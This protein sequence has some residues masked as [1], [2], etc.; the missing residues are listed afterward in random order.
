MNPPTPSRRQFLQTSLATAATF[1]TLSGRR[2]FAAEAGSKPGFVREDARDLPLINDANV[3]VCGAGPAGVTAAISAARAGAKVRLFEAHGSLGGVW[4]SSLLG[5]LLDFDKPGFNVELVRRLRE[6]DAINGSGMNGLSYQPEEMKLLLEELCVESGVKVQLHTRVAAAY[7]EGRSLSTIVTESKS[8][9][10]AWKAP[11]FID[12]TGD[13]DLGAQAGCEFEIGREKACPC[14]PMT[15]Y[16][17]LVVKDVAQIADCMHGTGDGGRHVGPKAFQDTLKRAGVT[18]SYGHACLFPIQGN[19]VLLMANHEYGI[20]AT[21]AA[22]VTEATLRARGEIHQIVRGLRKLGGPWDGLQVAATP[23][24][25]GIRDG[26]RIRGRY[27][28]T[29]ED[30]VKGA[31]QT[32]AVVR[33]T[34]PVDIHALSAE[35]NKKAAY[36]NA[37]VKVK[38]YDIPLRALI[39][40]DVD[41]LMMAGRCISGDFIA[42]ASYRVTGNAVAMGEAAGVTAAVAVKSKTA[43]HDVPWSE[44][45]PVIEKGRLG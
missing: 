15:M 8:G 23:E 42:H 19:L 7:R 24:Q 44:V 17:L 35:A 14:Q 11:V 9:R 40:R 5:Y 20:N 21:D 13:G 34:F 10:Q 29:S 25:I 4:T 1:G 30:L 38:P 18:P 33:A 39:A 26:R 27:I 16:A 12:A 22:Q 45:K 37:G 32:D 43:P 31:V 3:I 28:M 41:G 2:A 6:R 36:S